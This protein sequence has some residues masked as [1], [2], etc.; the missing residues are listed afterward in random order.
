[1]LA[2]IGTSSI[3]TQELDMNKI[4]LA[5]LAVPFLTMPVFAG[6]PAAVDK[7]IVVAQGVDVRVGDRGV[8]VGER[9]RHRDR[10]MRR[11]HRDHAPVMMKREHRH[12]DRDH[13]RR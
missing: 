13:D 3:L 10:D 9:D 6:S 11:H 2:R 5:L 1:M 8:R 12:R 7:P 4:A